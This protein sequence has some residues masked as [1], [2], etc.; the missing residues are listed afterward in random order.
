MSIA[1]IGVARLVSRDASCQACARILAQCTLTLGFVCVCVC[2]EHNVWVL[3]RYWIVALT[4]NINDFISVV[5]FHV[6]LI[7]QA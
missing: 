4:N 2:M 5:L 6:K 7:F 1:I 3:F